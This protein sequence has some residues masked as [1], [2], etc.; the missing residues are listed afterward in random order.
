MTNIRV[1]YHDGG[2]IMYCNL[3]TNPLCN[4][5]D[6]SK[7]QNHKYLRCMYISFALDLIAT[8]KFRK[9]TG[10]NFT[11]VITNL[12]LKLVTSKTLT[13]ENHHSL[14]AGGWRHLLTT[15]ATFNGLQCCLVL[16]PLKCN[17]GIRKEIKYITKKKSYSPK[18][19]TYT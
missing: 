18:Q 2:F 13:R 17:M 12:A 6:T 16:S 11:D 4:L 8:T 3:R 19:H 14:A 10:G 15:P 1:R 7:K 5:Y 9:H